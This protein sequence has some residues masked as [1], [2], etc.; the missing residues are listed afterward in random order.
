[1]IIDVT[2]LVAR[3]LDD[4]IP[5]GVDQ[6]SL[7]YVAYFK[8]TAY[9]LVRLK[10]MWIFLNKKDSELLFTFLLTKKKAEKIY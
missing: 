7:E 6:V 10:F 8:K 3:Q 4:I 5:S 1:M 2:R 9:A